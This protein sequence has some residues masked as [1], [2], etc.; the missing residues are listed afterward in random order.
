MQEEKIL[1]IYC[2]GACKGNPGI[3]GW[4]AYL[5]WGDIEKKLC[6]WA[7]RT[8]NNQMELQAAIEAL[9]AIKRPCKIR[10]TTDSNYVR[11]GICEWIWKWKAN[12]WKTSDKKDVKNVELWQE[13]DRL[14]QIFQP[15]WNWVKGHSGNPGNEMA[16]YL[17]NLAIKNSMSSRD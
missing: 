16:D 5:R 9:K 2:D 11:Q 12:G 1:E 13:L 4:G 10:I 14:N 8:T 15:Q 3:G 17:A 7:E 6:G